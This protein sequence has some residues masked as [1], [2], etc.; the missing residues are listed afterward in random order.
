MAAHSIW[1]HY[2]NC[3]N[4]C[5]LYINYSDIYV[6]YQTFIEY[7]LYARNCDKFFSMF[8]LNSQINAR[9]WLLFYYDPHFTE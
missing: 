9:S 1:V 4:V 7:F 6:S 3:N 8:K 2:R 5:Y